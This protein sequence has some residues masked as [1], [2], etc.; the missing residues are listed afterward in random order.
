MLQEVVEEMG[1]GWSLGRHD[2]K[3]GFFPSN[4]ARRAASTQHEHFVKAGGGYV[5]HA[6]PAG[7]GRARYP[8]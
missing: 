2:G 7:P 5:R 8:V 4:Y 1:E 6:T 3:M